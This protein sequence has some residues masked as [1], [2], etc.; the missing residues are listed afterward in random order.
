MHDF[1]DCDGVLLAA[2]DLDPAV[3]PVVNTL[4]AGPIPA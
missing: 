4:F 1:T 3:D 2:P